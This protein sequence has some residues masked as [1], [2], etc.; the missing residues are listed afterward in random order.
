MQSKP[1]RSRGNKILEDVHPLHIIME[2]Q[3]WPALYVRD[4][5]ERAAPHFRMK[6][7]TE[8]AKAVIP[9]WEI[10]SKAEK[11]SKLTD[12]IKKWRNLRDTFKRQLEVEKKIREGQNIKKKVYVYFKHMAFLLPHL[13]TGEEEIL[14]TPASNK[15]RRRRLSTRD[16]ETVANSIA[17][18]EEIDEDRHFLMSLVPSF[19]RMSDD[20]KLTAKMEILKVIRDVRGSSNTFATDTLA[21]TSLDS[22]KQETLVDIDVDQNVEG[23]VDSDD[24]EA[25]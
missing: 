12:L 9:D 3:K 1:T 24:D 22:I 11:Q 14:A 5:P 18:L 21:G 23:E 8:V 19:R 17:N 6:L 16:P 25:E 2:V 4:C 20:E 13:D 15:I 10:Y 7:W